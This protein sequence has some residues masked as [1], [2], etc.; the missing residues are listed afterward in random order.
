MSRFLGTKYS[1]RENRSK[2]SDE[3]FTTANIGICRVIIVIFEAHRKLSEAKSSSLEAEAGDW[4]IHALVDLF[5]TLLETLKAAIACPV[6]AQSAKRTK[7]PR[8]PT[9]SQITGD[10]ASR[11]QAARPLHVFMTSLVR[12]LS[13]PSGPM[14]KILQ[15]ILYLLLN[16]AGALLYTHTFNHARPDSVCEAII[17]PAATAEEKRIA[18]IEGAHLVPLIRVAMKHVQILSG[19]STDALSGLKLSQVQNTLVQAIFGVKET[20]LYYDVLKLPEA[21]DVPSEHGEVKWEDRE[22]FIRDMW[23]V[24]GWDVLRPAFNSDERIVA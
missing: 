4:T 20:T 9:S 14:F 23:E 1:Q 19:A 13:P 18:Q 22:I 11:V 5:R 8:P 17:A 7:T 16:R 15:G 2:A 10:T 21:I 12:D 24:C 3:Q 6:P